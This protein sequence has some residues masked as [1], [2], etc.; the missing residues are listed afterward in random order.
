[1]E[2]ITSPPNASAVEQVLHCPLPQTRSTVMISRAGRRMGFSPHQIR[3]L[4][5]PSE[6]R[7]VRLSVPSPKRGVMIFWGVVAL[8][9]MACG[10]YKGGVRL[11][12]DV[13]LHET[14]ELARLMTLKC[15]VTGVEFGGGKTGIR[16]EWPSIYEAHGRDYET[17]RDR[18][19]ELDVSLALMQRY[20]MRFRS[21]FK[22]HEYIPAP[23][24]GS[25]PEHMAIVF[26][27]TLDPATV[28]G[29]PENV[30]G[31]LP[32]RREAT[33]WGVSRAVMRVW[34]EQRVDP[35]DCTFA[36]QGFGNVGSWAAHFLA[37][38][39]ARMVAA[40]DALGGVY[41]ADGI[42][43]EG[44]REHT[45]ETGSVADFPD[46][47][48]I[49]P[50]EIYGVEC[51]VFIPAAIAGCIT[52]RTV[53]RLGCKVIVEGANMPVAP[54]GIDALADRDILV[55]PDI[56]A[57]SG[58]VVASME[59]YSKSLSA[60]AIARETVLGMITDRI[61][62]AMDR[63]EELAEDQNISLVEAATEIAMRRVYDAM[64]VRRFI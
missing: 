41:N 11:A 27:E 50:D 24:M 46:T 54:S 38:E 31:W 6:V 63:A 39:G 21:L 64:R 60:E 32:G 56:I 51:D 26:N 28:T 29:K 10:P 57:N 23:D 62:N 59:E 18:E 22:R 2:E 33:G 34:R 8:H 58:G 53:P 43:V 42:D 48:P 44:L 35:R 55:V 19:F 61:E 25:S 47:A 7:V 13:D 49:D 12:S 3:E 40:V 4:T 30:Q 16:V 14:L 36:L 15:A 37:E 1:M 9:N 52:E 20:A 5:A 45:L 17:E